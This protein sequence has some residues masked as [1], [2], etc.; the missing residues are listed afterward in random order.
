MY[1]F[2][3]YLEIQAF[4][5]CLNCVERDVSLACG[6]LP[7]PSQV[8]TNPFW[9]S[10]TS[11]MKFENKQAH[12]YGFWRENISI[13]G[14]FPSPTPSHPY[15]YILGPIT[16][17][18]KIPHKSFEEWSLFEIVQKCLSKCLS[19]F[20]S[21]SKCRLLPC[22]SGISKKTY[23]FYNSSAAEYRMKIQS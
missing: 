6:F 3:R 1:V 4:P 19:K 20:K 22:K 11:F 18:A 15:Y 2:G 8:R 10:G 7:W 14:L 13:T 17:V 9:C 12:I 16:H 5:A 23:I 21:L